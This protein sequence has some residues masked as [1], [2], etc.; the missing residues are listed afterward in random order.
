MLNFGGIRDEPDDDEEEQEQW[1]DTSY[2]WT[3]FGVPWWII[4]GEP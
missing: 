2:L 1:E 3:E 4:G